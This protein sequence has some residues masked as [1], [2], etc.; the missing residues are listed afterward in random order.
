M[1][2]TP[3]LQ[4]PGTGGGSITVT[5][6]NFLRA[7]SDL[8]FSAIALK[9]EGFGKFEHHRDV[10]SVDNQTIIRLN[11]DTLYSAA[12]LDLDAGP[13]T[14][15]LPDSGGR[16]MSLQI[17][18][19]DQ[20]V[21]AVYYDTQSHTL[22]REEIGTRYVLIG[23][24][25]LV[26]PADPDDLAVVH[27]LQDAI[28]LD[29][30]GGPGAFEI[31][32]WDHESQGKVREALL[33]LARTMPDTSKGFGKRGKVDPIQ[34][35][36]GGAMGW[37]ANPPEDATY[38]NIT[39]KLNDGKTVHRLRVKDVPVDAFWSVTV[40][41]ETGYIPKNEAGIYSYNSVTAKKGTDGSITIQFGGCDGGV[42]NCIPIVPGWNYMVRLYRPRSIILDGSWTFPEAQPIG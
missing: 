18:D 5:P 20:Y 22:T 35:L 23:V 40:Y 10:A 11:R 30:P 8:Y 31:P 34:R 38:L 15:T 13:A 14:I 28:R 2:G 42:A 17:I 24:R 3:S 36:V 1:N 29:Q 26:D 9:E 6:E 25:T 16:F 4:Q 32:D 7:E 41:D 21:P 19:E 12:L 37:G 39:P 27:A 33:A